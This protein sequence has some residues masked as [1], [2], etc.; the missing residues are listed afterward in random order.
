VSDR[1]PLAQFSNRHLCS[2]PGCQEFGAFGFARNSDG[3]DTGPTLWACGS[4]QHRQE[5][6]VMA[7]RA[8]Y[9]AKQAMP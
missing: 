9:S 1:D 7:Q 3:R 8:P 4:E 6:N 2:F 5:V